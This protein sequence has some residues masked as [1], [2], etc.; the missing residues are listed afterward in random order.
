MAN[1]QITFT[2]KVAAIFKDDYAKEP[3][4][5]KVVMDIGPEITTPLDEKEKDFYNPNF[6]ANHV[7]YLLDKISNEVLKKVVAYVHYKDEKF[8]SNIDKESLKGLEKKSPKVKLEVI[9]AT[10]EK[11]FQ[12][13][14]RNMERERKVNQIRYEK[15][16]PD[17]VL[18]SVLEAANGDMPPSDWPKSKN[19]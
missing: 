8:I 13:R 17:K 5:V 9:H 18:F 6:N 15:V 2:L 4:K 12:S 1:S 7:K 3:S 16:N 10:T 19:S 14:D 11:V